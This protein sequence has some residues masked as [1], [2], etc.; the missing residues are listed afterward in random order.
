MQQLPRSAQEGAHWL[1][2]HMAAVALTAV[3]SPAS[4]W[5]A[6]SGASHHMCNDRTC[7][8]AYKKLPTSI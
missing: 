3:Q 1:S 4:M 2:D 6:D 7:F 8:T 5:V